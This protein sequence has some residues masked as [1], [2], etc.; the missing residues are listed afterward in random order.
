MAY[1]VC[2]NEMLLDEAEKLAEIKGKISDAKASDDLHV[3]NDREE[4]NALILR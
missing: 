2:F 4:Q 3:L 1:Y